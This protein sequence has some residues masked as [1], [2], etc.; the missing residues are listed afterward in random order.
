MRLVPPPPLPRSAR[1]AFLA[2][3]LGAAVVPAG[4]SAAV[5]AVQG[6]GSWSA[7]APVSPHSG[8]NAGFA[9]VFAIDTPNGVNAVPVGDGW[10]TL[11]GA[12]VDDAPDVASFFGSDDGGMFN[13]SFH[14]GAI[15]AVSGA[16]VGSTGDL[17]AGT[18]DAGFT[19]FPALDPQPVSPAA[20]A[21]AAVAPAAV[22]FA[23]FGM[24]FFGM[25]SGMVTID[26]VAVSEP[27]TVSLFA[28]GLASFALAWGLRARRP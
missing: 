19:F 16:D 28:A 26:A 18:Y 12:A 20:F 15:L 2:F 13:L 1:L 7:D 10:F 27:P 14:S 6:H 3:L 23:T 8:P 5:V 9:F 22:A 21:P 17:L 25:G 4:A 11:N 24:G